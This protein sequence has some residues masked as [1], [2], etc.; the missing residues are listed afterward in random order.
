MKGNKRMIN[1]NSSH[2]Q[3]PASCSEIVSNHKHNLNENKETNKS[4]SKRRPSIER[5]Q[6]FATQLTTLFRVCCVDSPS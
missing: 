5:K 3:Q 1:D 6:S 4:K 2:S